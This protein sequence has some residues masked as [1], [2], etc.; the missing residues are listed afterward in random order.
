M[1]SRRC[2]ALLL[3]LPVAAGAVELQSPGFPPS[4]MEADGRLVEDWGAVGVR[5]TGNAVPESGPI[6][7]EA[8][9]LEQLIP[10]ARAV[11]QRGP[12][13]LTLTAYRAP[14]WPA[15]VDVLTVRVEETRGQPA[16]ITLGLDLPAKARIGNRTVALGNRIVVTCPAPQ[17]GEVPLRDWGYCDDATSM[18]NWGKPIGAC[19]PAFRNIRAALNGG[20]IR[21]QFSVPKRSTANVVL[22]FCESHSTE[23]GIRPLV[24]HV[25]GAP[26]QTVDPIAKWG[27]HKPGVLQF[28]ARDENR[29]G[30]LDITVRTP[31]GA[32]DRN[33]ILNAIWIYPSATTVKLEDVLAGSLNSAATY[34]VDVGGPKDQSLFPT[35]KVE[36]HLRL[37]ANSARELT[38]C[39]A[40]VGSSAPTPST[41]AW[42]PE[43]LYRAAL[44]V[45]QGV[46]SV[47]PESQKQK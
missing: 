23:L 45:W 24:C 5:L 31:A 4:R 9:K 26:P 15:G 16:A 1:N 10:A 28:D 37:P 6:R 39:V 29:D 20:T 30:K 42:T 21:Y 40:C 34:Y 27:R 22:G 36:Y 41:S 43:T 32:A 12:V 47:N 44:N 35:D 38:F 46:S 3:W 33:P 17:A 25:E 19:D 13:T 18:P 7:V 2:L 8:V 14:V 11:A